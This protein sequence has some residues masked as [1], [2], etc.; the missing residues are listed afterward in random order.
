MML[1]SI[2][3]VRAARAAEDRPSDAGGTDWEEV[4]QVLEIRSVCAF[5]GEMFTCNEIPA[6][7]RTTRP[8]PGS[9]DD[10]ASADASGEDPGEVAVDGYGTETITVPGPVILAGARCLSDRIPG[11]SQ[12]RC[13]RRFRLHGVIPRRAVR[14][15]IRT[16]L[17]R[18]YRVSAAPESKAAAQWRCFMLIT[19]DVG[20]SHTVIGVYEDQRLLHH[21]RIATDIQRTTD[22]HGALLGTLLASAGLTPPLKP[23]GVAIA[24]V[25]PPLNQT[26]EQLSRR[27][28][29]CEPLVVGPGIKTGMPD[30]LREPARGRRRSDRQT[31]SRPSI[32]T[33]C[34]YRGRFRHRHHV[35]LRHRARRVRRR[36]DRAGTGRSRWTR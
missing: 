21:W 34:M 27:Y 18:Y 35:R 30:P 16:D 5:D 7:H 20:N 23:E 33:N 12:R 11:L 32:D 2:A 24:C 22:E 26:M 14:R 13:R 28:F 31:R 9:S 17:P 29:Q 8:R 36:R 4:N 3:G 15:F 6:Q 10:G 25:V 19:I 1:I